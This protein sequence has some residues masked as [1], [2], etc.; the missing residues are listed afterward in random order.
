MQFVGVDAGLEGRGGDVVG[1]KMLGEG[2]GGFEG[3]GGGG[4]GGFLVRRVLWGE[5]F[6]GCGGGGDGGG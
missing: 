3:T 1:G 6:R 4:G 5:G 2:V